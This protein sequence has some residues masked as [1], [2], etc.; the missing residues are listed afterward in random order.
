[1]APRAWAHA[2][3]LNAHVCVLLDDF[4]NNDG[5]ARTQDKVGRI[6]CLYCYECVV[7]AH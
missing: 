3:S 7:G 2:V 1:M 4:M 5:N 6:G